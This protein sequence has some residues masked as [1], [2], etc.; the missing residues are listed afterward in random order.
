LLDNPVFAFHQRRDIYCYRG[1][2]YAEFPEFLRFPVPRRGFKQYFGGNTAP[3]HTG[4]AD[5]LFFNQQN[6]APLLAA[7]HRG[8][9]PA[10]PRA[11]NNNVKFFIN[12]C[13][14]V[15]C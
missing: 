4:P 14:T 9:A 12:H 13:H 15:S 2:L 7:A 11:D 10:R 1:C 5:M 6:P 8:R 3:M